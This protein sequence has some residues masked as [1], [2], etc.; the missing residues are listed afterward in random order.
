MAT[1]LAT[2]PLGNVIT[3]D[4]MISLISERPGAMPISF[5][6]RTEV[7]LNKKHRDTK[8]PNRF[9]KVFKT[10]R[11]AGWVN[12]S[13]ETAARK[14]AEANGETYEP[15]ETWHEAALDINEHLTPFAE[16][17][18]TGKL[19]LRV[20]HPVNRES[21]MATEH[22]KPVEWTDLEGF[23]APKREESWKPAFRTYGLENILSVTFGGQTYRVGNEALIEELETA[24]AL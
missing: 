11:V 5:V 16:K 8:E 14:A 6:A 10:A 13:Y 17:P 22:G 7:K 12:C 4:E 19:Y 15:G 9:G 3:V 1:L 18:E 24:I 23:T 21:S 2:R 20:L